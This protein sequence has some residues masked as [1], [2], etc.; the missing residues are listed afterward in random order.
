MGEEQKVMELYLEH[1]GQVREYRS[2]R[3]AIRRGHVSI[4]GSG[5]PARPFNNRKNTCTR[6]KESRFNNNEAKQ[7][8]GEL[9]K[10]QLAGI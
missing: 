9:K 2:V 5:Y 7:I 10:R 4:L 8:Y 6:G 1:Y 3:R